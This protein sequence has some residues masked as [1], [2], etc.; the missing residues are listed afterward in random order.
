M[1][2]AMLATPVMAIGPWQ[3]EEVGSNPNLHADEEP[4]KVVV[5]DTS[6]VDIQWNDYGIES[7]NVW[8]SADREQYL[9]ASNAKI[10]NAVLGSF[11]LFVSM[12]TDPEVAS[13]YENKWIFL[14]H[15]GFMVYL[16]ALGFSPIDAAQIASQYPDGL[17][18]R[19]INVGQ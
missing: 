10:K 19:Y 7:D 16:L 12:A 5:L 14:T 4:W 6:N 17:Y 15:D 8:R 9:S 13:E 18:Y 3:A 1:A 2:V 11:E